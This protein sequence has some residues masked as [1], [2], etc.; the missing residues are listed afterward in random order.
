MDNPTFFIFSEDQ[1]W[2]KNNLEQKSNFIMISP[3][4]GNYSALNDMYLI[5][6]CKHHIV[7]NSSFYWWG[8]WLA[9]NKNKIVVASDCFL[10]PQSIP[11]SWIKF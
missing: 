2:V 1:E 6:L 11:D 4:E 10:N 7:S 5:S 9:N 8:A 3:K